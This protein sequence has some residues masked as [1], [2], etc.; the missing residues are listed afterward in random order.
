MNN[1]VSFLD[2]ILFA[3]LPY[4]VFLFFFLG[5]IN[6]YRAEAFT[7]S[8]LSTQFLENR[9]HFWGS[10]PLHFGILTVLAGHVVAFLIPRHV[11]LW[12]S[13]P[14]RLYILE[15]SALIFGILA[16]VGFVSA[17]LRRYADIKVRV[18]TSLLDWVIY[19][20]LILQA[21]SGVYIAIFHPWGSSWF[22]ASISPYLWSLV[23]F[24]PDITYLA[25][26]P[27]AVKLHI[28]CFYL[29][30][31]LFPFSRLVHILVV[32]NPYL[33]RKPQVV[34]WYSRVSSLAGG[35]R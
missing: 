34:R 31:G 10:V 18:V 35:K 24:N 8:S 29:L 13:K 12:N 28:V 27:L 23:R 26:M 15:I 22:A 4:A 33:W 16:V 7:Y 1:P 21:V 5:T 25:T 17:A 9:N 19:G 14:L 30:I 11:L 3:A 32:P 2:P 20:L 6:R